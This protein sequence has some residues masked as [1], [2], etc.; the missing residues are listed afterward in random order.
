MFLCLFVDDRLCK[1][2]VCDKLFFFMINLKKY[3]NIYIGCKVFCRYC[4][5]VF[6]YV[7]VFRKYIRFFYFIIYRERLF[8]LLERQGKLGIKVYKYLDN[9]YENENSKLFEYGSIYISFNEGEKEIKFKKEKRIKIRIEDGIDFRFKFFCIICKKRFIEYVNMCR[10]RRMVYEILDDENNSNVNL[11]GSFELVN[12]V[13]ENLEVIVVFF[14]NVVYNIVEN[15]ICY[16]DGGQDVIEVYSKRED[17]EVDVENIDEDKKVEE[18]YNIVLY[19]YNFFYSY[20]FRLFQENF[21]YCFLDFLEL[22]KK[23]EKEVLS[24]FD[25][26]IDENFLDDRGFVFC[27]RRRNL[28]DSKDDSRDSIWG[29]RFDG[30]FINLFVKFER[31]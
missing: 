8:K 20:N 5:A 31:S 27:I 24:Y 23:Y 12:I 19:Q 14:V 17:E 7:G 26:N 29:N 16:L 28:K 11:E 10:Y 25:V 18:F 15:L 1:C 3:M 2:I 30:S 13:V 6:F 22:M 9:S 4:E 21:E